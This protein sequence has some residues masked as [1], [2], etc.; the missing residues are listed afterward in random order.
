MLGVGGGRTLPRTASQ[1]PFRLAS[2]MLLIV[3]A[4]ALS[5]TI[6]DEMPPRGVPR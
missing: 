6:H 5:M 1:T 4:D 2:Y 3:I